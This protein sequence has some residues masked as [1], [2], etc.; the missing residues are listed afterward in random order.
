MDNYSRTLYTCPLRSKSDAPVGF[1][2][3]KAAAENESQKKLRP[4]TH[5]GFVWEKVKEI[6][7]KE[8]IRLHTSVRYSSESNGVAQRTH[9]RD[10]CHAA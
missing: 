2:V 5:V 1:K 9:Q 6:C 8:G 3:F 4:T 7:E 10:A